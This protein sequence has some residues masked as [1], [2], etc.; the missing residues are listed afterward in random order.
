MPLY[1]RGSLREFRIQAGAIVARVSTRVNRSESKKHFLLFFLSQTRGTGWWNSFLEI[2]RVRDSQSHRRRRQVHAAY[3]CDSGPTL[4]KYEL[5]I[6][7]CKF[8]TIECVYLSSQI[9]RSVFTRFN[10]FSYRSIIKYLRLAL[11]HRWMENSISS[12][13]EQACTLRVR[14]PFSR[15][16]CPSAWSCSATFVINKPLTTYHESSVPAFSAERRALEPSCNFAGRGKIQRYRATC[17]DYRTPTKESRGKLHERIETHAVLTA[18]RRLCVTRRSRGESQTSREKSKRTI[19]NKHS[20]RLTS[21]WIRWEKRMQKSKLIFRRLRMS[22]IKFQA[23]DRTNIEIERV[24]RKY[25]IADWLSSSEISISNIRFGGRNHRCLVPVLSL[26][27]PS[28]KPVLFREKSRARGKT[29]IRPLWL[30]F[31]Y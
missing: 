17:C 26:S 9:V 8:G 22:L 27:I 7:P 24:H 14:R 13:S 10:Y 3:A 2:A 19:E 12:L 28:A 4:L 30:C 1:R 16:F 15:R 29:D 5:Q 31:E 18:F 11:S 6:P 25:W 21:R 23:N 20:G